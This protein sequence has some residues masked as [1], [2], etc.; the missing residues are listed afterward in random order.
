VP[1]TTTTSNALLGLQL[2]RLSVP[3]L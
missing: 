2:P 1:T 3:K